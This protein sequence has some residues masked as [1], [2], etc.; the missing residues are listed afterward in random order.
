[1]FERLELG[2]QI[3]GFNLFEI[4][5]HVVHIHIVDGILVENDLSVGNIV[6]ATDTSDKHGTVSRVYF[7]NQANVLNEIVIEWFYIR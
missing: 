3:G 7:C 2:Q 6:R 5:I 4:I 1:M